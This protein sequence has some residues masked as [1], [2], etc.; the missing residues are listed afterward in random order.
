MKI[1]LKSESFIPYNRCNSVKDYSASLLY[2]Y[3]VVS[4]KFRV[5]QVLLN[6]LKRMNVKTKLLYDIY[7]IIIIQYSIHREINAIASKSHLPPIRFV[8]FSCNSA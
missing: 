6:V 7:Y 2:E 3:N 5:F 4:V 8:K 1:Y